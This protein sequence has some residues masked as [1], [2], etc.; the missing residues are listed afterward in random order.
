MYRTALLIAFGFVLVLVAVVL[1]LMPRKTEP[2]TGPSAETEPVAVVEPGWLTYEDTAVTFRY[3]QELP[4]TY[5]SATEWP[6][7]VTVVEGTVACSTS[8]TLVAET[9]E[10]EVNGRIYCV[11]T[12]SEGA[13]GSVYV[14]YG[15]ATEIERKTVTLSF[16]SRMTQCANYDDP[17]RTECVQERAEFD[18]DNLIDRI[19]R[20]LEFKR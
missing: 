7:K 19:V 6:P 16:T 20:T 14:E 13:A 12:R 5:I 11:T 4:A 8:G 1:V 3:P 9:K 15:Y 17:Q 18:T 2:V 10:V